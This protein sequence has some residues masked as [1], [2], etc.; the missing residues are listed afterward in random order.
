ITGLSFLAVDLAAKQLELLKAAVPKLSRVAVLQNPG[1]PPHALI[2]REV[3]AAARTLGVTLLVLGV[4]V[5]DEFE[6]AFAAMTRDRAGALLVLPDP[7]SL[8]HRTRVAELAAKHRLP[9]MYGLVDHAAA[10]GL[11]AYAVDARHN[12]RRAATYV[13]KI[14]KGARP[15]DLPVEQPTRMEFVVNLKTAK[16]L[17]LTIPQ[18]VLIRADRVIQ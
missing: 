4:R 10:G 5:P 2:L 1:L 15:A 17:G 16:A 9:V 6:S 14:L 13:D 8:I 18:S 12:W 3:E 11:M 7:M